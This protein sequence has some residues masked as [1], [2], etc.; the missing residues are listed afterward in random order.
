MGDGAPEHLGHN[1]KCLPLTLTSSG[2]GGKCGGL[3]NSG[4]WPEMLPFPST[5]R[6]LGRSSSGLGKCWGIT[7]LTPLSDPPRVR[8]VL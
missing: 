6:L 7:A 4:G 3:F 8:H 1:A 5:V 2:A